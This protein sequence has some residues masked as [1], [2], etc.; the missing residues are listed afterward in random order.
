VDGGVASYQFCELRVDARQGNQGEL[1]ADPLPVSE[2]D[3]A[4]RN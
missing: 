4:A 2:G 3:V 1:P